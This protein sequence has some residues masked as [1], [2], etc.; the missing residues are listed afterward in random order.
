M[1][2][3]GIVVFSSICF[4]NKSTLGLNM[5]KILTKRK[6]YVYIKKVID[7]CQNHLHLNTAMQMI[8]NFQLIHDGREYTWMNEARDLVDLLVNRKEKIEYMNKVNLQKGN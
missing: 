7:S 3:I 5:K 1:V 8:K 6:E 4:S 2:L